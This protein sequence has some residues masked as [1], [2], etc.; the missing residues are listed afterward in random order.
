M[1]AIAPVTFP[2]P[3]H[4]LHS[5][6]HFHYVLVRRARCSRSWRAYVLLGCR[7]WTG[8]CTD[9]KLA[10]C[11]SGPSA[12]LRQRAVSSRSHL[13][14]PRGHAA[15]HPRLLD[16]VRGL[17]HGLPIGAVASPSQLLFVYVI[18]SGEGGQKAQRKCGTARACTVS[19][20]PSPRRRRTT[21]STKRRSSSEPQRSTAADRRA[22]PAH[23]AQR[24]R[25]R[26]CWP[27]GSTWPSSVSGRDGARAMK[28]GA[29][30]RREK[31][32]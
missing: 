29:D 12:H 14:R 8:T 20:G 3:R 4:L 1:M 32:R 11:T 2:V 5:C 18:G 16:A 15:A 17:E 22:A 31:A 28:P 25:A 19:S 23:P 27:S 24:R 21:R 9:T 10:N 7:S 6:A 26:G 30:T 13:P